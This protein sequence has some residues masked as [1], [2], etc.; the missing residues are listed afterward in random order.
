VKKIK[1]CIKG[2]KQKAARALTAFFQTALRFIIARSE[3]VMKIIK[4]DAN[5][6]II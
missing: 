6:G 4:K 1:L 5:L 3:L 2:K